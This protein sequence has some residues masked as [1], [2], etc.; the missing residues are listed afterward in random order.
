MQNL[1]K[2][3]EGCEEKGNCDQ[4]ASAY[5]DRHLVNERELNELCSKSVTACQAKAREIYEAVYK[6]QAVGYNVE[7]GG[8]PAEILNA[9]HHM[10][11]A[12]GPEATQHIALPSVESFLDALG[13]DP[14]S[15]STRATA[16]LL[17][18][19]VAGK[20]VRSGKE[21]YLPNAGGVNNMGEFFAQPG[22]GTE[23]KT[24]SRKTKQVYD[25]QSVYEA[26]SDIGEY[27]QRGDRFYL[28]GAHKNHLEVFNDKGRAK[29][30]LNLDGTLNAPKTDK[31]VQGGR[32]LSK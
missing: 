25:G 23:V 26:S 24:L 15:D 5:F 2:D 20:A 14:T 16:V 17:A 22:F 31:A 9:F 32:R 11:L 21:K 1:A 19:I 6:W 30:V 8:R 27:I 28:D 10:N 4:I 7:L 29:A 13:L 3:L 12:A 18:G